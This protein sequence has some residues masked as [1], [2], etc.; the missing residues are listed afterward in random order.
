MGGGVITGRADVSPG[1]FS[2]KMKADGVHINSLPEAQASGFASSGTVDGTL[3]VYSPW[4]GCPT[5]FV[6]LRTGRIDGGDLRFMGMPLALG[7]IEQAGLNATLASCRVDVEGLWVDAAE[8]SARLSGPVF[9]AVPMAASRID[10]TLEI[11]PRGDL[12]KKHWLFS[13]IGQYRK[14]SNYYFMTIRGTLARPVI[15]R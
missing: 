15:G 11:T 5:G 7:D 14:N 10:M 3:S 9:F 4:H 13:L 8:L 2:L 1:G 12:S 6:K